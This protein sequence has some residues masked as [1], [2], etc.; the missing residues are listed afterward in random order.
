MNGIKILQIFLG[1]DLRNGDRG[2]NYI[3]AKK[4]KTLQQN[5]NKFEVYVFWNGKRDLVKIMSQ[6]SILVQRLKGA[7]RRWDPAVDRNELF[8]LIGKAFNLQ[9]NVNTQVYQQLQKAAGVKK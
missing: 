4:K 8:V 6:D 9:F 1:I 3:L 5:M 7:N 2:L